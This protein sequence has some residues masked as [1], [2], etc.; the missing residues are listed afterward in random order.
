MK[1]LHFDTAEAWIAAAVKEFRAAHETATGEG[2][3]LDIVLAGGS[4]PGPIYRA[5]AA[6]DLGPPPPRL[7]PGDER[8]LPLGHPERNDSPIATLL[9][10]AAW[11][12]APELR[13][14]PDASDIDPAQ[15]YAKGLIETLS[16]SPRFDLAFL[17]I[18][19]DGHTAGL[20]PGDAESL[21][22]LDPA[23][24]KLAV[25]TIAPARPWL[26]MTM[27]AT[28]L[29]G[30]RRMVF[31]T[32]GGDKLSMLER[33]MGDEGRDRPWRQVAALAEGRGAEVLLFHLDEA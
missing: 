5:L 23:C 26:R 30:A 3:S 2:R 11:K 21:A 13:A 7:W 32:K 1:L 28:A 17:G 31:L 27:T 4:T 15:T 10:I 18:G 33:T 25:S 29:A 9:S 8:R 24:T 20:F 6:L 19:S 12:P 16:S 14:W 22:G